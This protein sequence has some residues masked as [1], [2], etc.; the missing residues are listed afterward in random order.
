MEEDAL[1]LKFKLA[2]LEE[3]G[4][5][6]VGLIGLAVLSPLITGNATGPRPIGKGVPG[7][8]P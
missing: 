3:G 6:G 4:N 1:S 2:I 7:M 8:P 5:I